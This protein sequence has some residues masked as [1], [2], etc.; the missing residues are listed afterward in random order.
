MILELLLINSKHPDNQKQG[1]CNVLFAQQSSI[2]IL[3]GLPKAYCDNTGTDLP[4]F[5]DWMLQGP[6]VGLATTIRPLHL[7]IFNVTLCSVSHPAIPP[8]FRPFPFYF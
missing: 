8:H 4:C 2:T 1:A 3:T 7:C 6:F 5:R